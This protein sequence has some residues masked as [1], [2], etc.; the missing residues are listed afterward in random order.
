MQLSQQERTTKSQV[1]QCRADL[2][3]LKGI[4]SKGISVETMKLSGSATVVSSE[5]KQELQKS[6]NAIDTVLIVKS[7]KQFRFSHLP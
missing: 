6:L 3:F 5:V 4:L 2:D 1:K 7:R